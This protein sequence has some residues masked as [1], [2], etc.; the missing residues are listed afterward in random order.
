[1]V[2]FGSSC[3]GTALDGKLLSY[4]AIN[5]ISVGSLNFVPINDNPKGAPLELNTPKGTVTIGYP[6][7]NIVHRH[8][9]E[10]SRA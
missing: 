8:T 3:N 2:A 10:G 9:R 7:V 6:V 4:A 1:M 5:R